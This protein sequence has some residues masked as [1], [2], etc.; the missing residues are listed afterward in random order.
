MSQSFIIKSVKRPN[1]ICSNVKQN[2]AILRDA[3]CSMGDDGKAEEAYKAASDLIAELINPNN[4]DGFY[5][6]VIDFS[7]KAEVKHN[8]QKVS[9]LQNFPSLLRMKANPQNAGRIIDV[10]WD[11]SAQPAQTVEIRAVARDRTGLLADVSNAI[12]ARGIFIE[13][14]SSRSNRDATATLRFTLLVRSA[15]QLNAVMEQ[16]RR[17][18]GVVEL[19]CSGRGPA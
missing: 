12:T 18:K 7:T 16:L 11:S 14:S 8:L 5:A 9:D 19:T 15:N 3:S 13:S 17:V 1:W 6:T 4:K 2:I 10:A